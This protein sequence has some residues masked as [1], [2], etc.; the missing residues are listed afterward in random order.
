MWKKCSIVGQATDDN[1]TRRMRSAY[2]IPKATDTNSEYVILIALPLQQC[3]Y[4]RASMLRYTYTA[5]LVFIQL[6]MVYPTAS[7][8]CNVQWLDKSELESM[9][10]RLV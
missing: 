10:K 3:L 4:E 8:L 2:C 9:R 5:F 6:C 1:V 7:K